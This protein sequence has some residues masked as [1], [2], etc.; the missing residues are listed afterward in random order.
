[1]MDPQL[2]VSSSLSPSAERTNQSRQNSRGTNRVHFE[3]AQDGVWELRG[4]AARD[5]EAGVTDRR[6]DQARLLQHLQQRRQPVTAVAAEQVHGASLTIIGRRDHTAC[7]AGCDALLTRLAGVVLLVRSADCVP[8]LFADPSRRVVGIAHAGWRG[9]AAG[10]PARVIA[11]FHHAFGSRA[12]DV[13]V[14]VGPAI[15]LCCY[16]V[17][18]EFSRH[19]GSFVQE[20]GD[21]RT[22]DLIG[23]AAQQLRQAGVRPAYIT[24][25]QHCTACEPQHWFSLRREGPSTGRLTSFIMI[26]PWQT[27]ERCEV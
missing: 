5:I 9:L 17:G 19:F 11:A 18:A 2:G 8:L 16:D 15:R 6:L 24:D 23:V 10:L 13:R 21:R 3:K 4:W 20:R 27:G 12:D 22:C 26:R 1:M 25:T 7:V 14:A